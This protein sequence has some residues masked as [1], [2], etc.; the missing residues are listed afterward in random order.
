M[1]IASFGGKVIGAVCN[2]C[3]G[4]QTFERW[5]AAK[6]KLGEPQLGNITI[7][8]ARRYLLVLA[9]FMVA[10]IQRI[11]PECDQETQG[12]ITPP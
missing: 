1:L 10:E 12:I 6:A 9:K 5:R 3:G 7:G 8:W 4:D 2:L 11:D